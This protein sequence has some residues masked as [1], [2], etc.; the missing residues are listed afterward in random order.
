MP[1]RLTLPQ[2]RALV[3]ALPAHRMMAVKKHCNSCQMKGQGLMDIM[4]SIGSVLG[5]IIKEVGPTVLKELIVPFI[6]GQMG[7]GLHIPGGGLS[8]PG[9]SLRL[10]GQRGRGK[11]KVKK[12]M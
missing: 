12:K 2:Q 11:K 7:K 10:A 9:G 4:K 1:T 3:R 8:L 6:K 5:P